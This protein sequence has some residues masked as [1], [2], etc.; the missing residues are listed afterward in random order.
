MSLPSPLPDDPRKWTGWK[1]Y[2]SQNFYERL[3]LSVEQ[4]PSNELIE[5]HTRQLLVWWQK[6]LPLKN[7]PSNPLAQIL[8]DGLDVAPSF[9]AEARLGLCNPVTR[10]TIDES[11]L[12]SAKTSMTAEFR[13]VFSIIAAGNEL[14]EDGE[15][16]LLRF[17]LKHGFSEEEVAALIGEEMASQNVTRIV[18]EAAPP[19]PQA[20]SIP[21]SSAAPG[22]NDPVAEFKRFLKLS[23]LDSDSMTDDQRDALINMA[24][25]LGLNGGDAEDIVDDYLEE[26][27]S[28]PQKP[29]ATVPPPTPLRSPS[30]APIKSSPV[31][32]PG[33]PAAVRPNTPRI[34]TTISPAEERSKYPNFTNTLGQQLLLVPSGTFLM[35]STEPDAAPNEGPCNKVTVSRFYMSR[36][37]ATCAVY[38][39][40]SPAH[41]SNRIPLA[42]DNHPVLYVSSADAIKFCQWLSQ[43]ERRKYRLPT[44]AEWEYAARGTDNRIYPWGDHLNNP[45]ALGNFADANTKFSWSDMEVND[46]F[47]ETSPVGQYPRGA[48]AFGIEDMAGNVWEWCNDYFENY[49]PNDRI[50]PKGPMNGTKRVY[51]GGSW[52]SRFS[53]LR[54]TSRNSNTVDYRCND[55]GFRIVCECE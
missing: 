33:A 55:L 34:T 6:K 52:K 37:P 8:R 24:E 48:S 3:C 36:H 7:Q 9:L 29:G 47:A 5:D 44:E 26:L 17:G 11:L 25:N 53:S 2:N 12:A 18:R 30:P 31:A 49:K 46:G 22:G 20:S 42:G 45:G 54:A 21:I 15:A 32:K 4:N 38:E 35:G 23:G 14:S 16:S 51:R 43:K 41:R 39:Q 27:D 40:F 28:Q 1:N 50:N 19:P 13:R 10:K